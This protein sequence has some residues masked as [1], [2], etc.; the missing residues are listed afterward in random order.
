MKLSP[1]PPLNPPTPF[2]LHFQAALCS[3][4]GGGYVRTCLIH[5][6]SVLSV[7]VSVEYLSS[8]QSRSI[9]LGLIFKNQLV[10]FMKSESSG[11]YK[12][13]IVSIP[14]SCSRNLNLTFFKLKLKHPSLVASL[15]WTNQKG[16]SWVRLPPGPHPRVFQK[17]FTEK[18]TSKV[19][20]CGQYISTIHIF[21][22]VP[23]RITL[24]GICLWGCR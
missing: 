5:V 21:F 15:L 9:R 8:G 13:F 16:G 3:L 24:V 1:F 6:R 23:F 4:L 12:T 19:S 20:T 11:F 10:G 18:N 2:P 22:L 17:S 7:W 14:D